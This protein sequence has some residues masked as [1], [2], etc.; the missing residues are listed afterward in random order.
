[1]KLTVVR[2]DDAIQDKIK[3]R[4]THSTVGKKGKT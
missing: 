3:L 4:R 2:V 1:L